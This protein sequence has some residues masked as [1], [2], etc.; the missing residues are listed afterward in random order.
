MRLALTRLVTHGILS[1]EQMKYEVFFRNYK[2]KLGLRDKQLLDRKKMEN[3]ELYH[4]NIDI[5]YILRAR[6]HVLED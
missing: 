2:E 4:F 5:M 1:S 3:A 6:M